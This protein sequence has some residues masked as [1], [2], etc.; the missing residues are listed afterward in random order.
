MGLVKID[1]YGRVT[2]Y[3]KTSEKDKKL[4]QS[5]QRTVNSINSE[6]VNYIEDN[7]AT[8]KLLSDEI[9]RLRKRLANKHNKLEDTI[10]FIITFIENDIDDIHGCNE[11]YESGYVDCGA[12]IIH[13]LNE[14]LK[15]D[16]NAND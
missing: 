3:S 1:E 2:P 12:K 15:A 7:E 9:S 8:L 4:L 13:I 16:K 10:N 11:R 6:L 5:I 14:I